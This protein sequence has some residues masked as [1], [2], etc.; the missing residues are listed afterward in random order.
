[1]ILNYTPIT[2]DDKMMALMNMKH[3]NGACNVFF[4][5]RLAN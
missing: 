3:L 1:M 2:L 5:F 4:L